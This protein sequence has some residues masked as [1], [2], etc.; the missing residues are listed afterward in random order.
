MIIH[1]NDIEQA[2]A[3]MHPDQKM[4]VG[5]ER[6]IAKHGLRACFPDVG[7]LR[8]VFLDNVIDHLTAG[9]DAGEAVEII[10]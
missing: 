10:D 6:A 9:K 2:I 7:S 3:R 1:K 8:T 5:V 4:M